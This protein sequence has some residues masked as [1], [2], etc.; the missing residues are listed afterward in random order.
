MVRDSSKF[1]AVVMWPVTG[2]GVKKN[3]MTGSSISLK[4]NSQI[5]KRRN[6]LER[7]V[8]AELTGRTVISM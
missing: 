8:Y 4:K 7:L 5:E 2:Q 3:K 6:E 1:N